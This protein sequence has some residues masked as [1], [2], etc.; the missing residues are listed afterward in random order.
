[1]RGEFL[2]KPLKGDGTMAELPV[3]PPT[4]PQASKSAAIRVIAHI[5]V[6]LLALAGVWF[7]YDGFGVD[8]RIL[9]PPGLDP[10]GIPI[11]FFLLCLAGLTAHFLIFK[12][13]QRGNGDD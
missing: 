3:S 11:G 6:V 2:L 8:F 12:R 7:L 5:L 1:M 10:Y 13:G 4:T 9:D